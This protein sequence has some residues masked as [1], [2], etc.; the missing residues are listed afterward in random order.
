MTSRDWK[1]NRRASSIAAVALTWAFFSL[2]LPA[3]AQSASADPAPPAGSEED[4]AKQLSNPVASLISVPLQFNYDRGIGPGHDGDKYFVNVQPVIP[5]SLS[6]DWNLISR[7]IVPIINQNHIFP[8]AGSQTGLGD[9]LQSLFFSPAKPVGGVI[10]GVGPAFLL[11]TGTDRLLSA[12]KFGLGPT[13][14][15]LMQEGPW[16]FGMLFNHIWSVAGQESRPHVS[17]TFLQ[18]FLAYTT[19]DGWTFTLNTE[20]TYDWRSEDWSVPLNFLLAKLTKIGGQPVQF[21]AGPRYWAESP[22]SGPHGWGVRFNVI[23]LFP[24]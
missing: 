15:G 20:T 4:L 9:I 23:L 19:K 3:G 21:Q 7:T 16:T 8:G 18:P 2:A 24:K 14:V 17:N 1:Q 22:R 12:R 10:L 5:F 11:P 13:G 6:Q